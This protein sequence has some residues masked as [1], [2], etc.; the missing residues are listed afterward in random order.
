[1]SLY[2]R[3]LLS[4]DSDIG[5]PGPLPGDL[6]G[7]ADESLA[8]LSWVA[9]SQGYVGAGYFPVADPPQ[10]VRLITTRDFMR[11]LT[12]AELLAIETAAET[13]AQIRVLLRLLYAGPTVNLD[14]ADTVSALGYLTSLGLLASGRSAEIRA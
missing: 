11:R 3:K 8:D 6:V 4:D 10:S 13:N 12:S 2:Q 5:E 9:A 14:V 1:M 7:L